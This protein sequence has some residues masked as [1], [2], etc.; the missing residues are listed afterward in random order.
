M[1]INIRAY[2]QKVK[3][4]EAKLTAAHSSN[5]GSPNLSPGMQ[6]MVD[7]ALSQANQRL[8]SLK[9][10]HHNLVTKYTELEIKYIELQAGQEIENLPGNSSNNN[11]PNQNRD[12]NPHSHIGNHYN[13]NSFSPTEEH[14]Y[15]HRSH[16]MHSPHHHHTFS[17]GGP[18]SP[19]DQSRNNHHHQN[20]PYFQPTS[21]SSHN[22]QQMMPPNSPGFGSMMSPHT[23]TYMNFNSIR[24]GTMSPTP[25]PTTPIPPTPIEMQHHRD[26][27]QQHRQSYSD[28]QFNDMY[29]RAH[30]PQLKNMPSVPESMSMS[31]TN[32]SRSVKTTGSSQ[33]STAG[34]RRK[35]EK[36][37]PGTE[38]VRGRG[39]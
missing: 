36:T 1:N 27:Q 6:A 16:Q 25:P 8:A 4:L 30:G 22:S 37:K 28:L 24:Y 38:R 2:E 11:N 21:N 9:K 17:E 26:Q 12:G 20:S 14:G 18:T 5:S 7:S 15:P 35:I 32:D 33:D 19:T 10:A 13:D 34:E 39:S 23:P 29:N 3:E 31:M